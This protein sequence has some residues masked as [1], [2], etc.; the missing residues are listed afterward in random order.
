MTTD[1]FKPYGIGTLELRNRFVRSATWDAT[2]DSSGTVTDNSVALYRELGQGGVG[3]IVTGYAYISPLG[4]TLHGQYGAHTNDMIPGLRRLVQV[5]HQG[6][7]KIALQIV[8][9]GIYSA[10]LSQRSIMSLAVSMMPEINNPHR[11]MTEEEIVAIIS[12]FASAA[13]RAREAGFDAVQLHGAH[14]FLMSQFLSP[15][16]NCRTDRWGSSP[17]NRRRFHIE[18][19]ERIRKVV[20]T[21]FPLMIKFGVQDDKE[22]GLTLSEGLETVH[23][24]VEH[25]IAAIEVSAGFGMPTQ[26]RK[27]GELEQA[28]FRERAATVK[29]TV[30]VPVTA[31][32][33]IRS[34]EM[35]QGIVESGDA[36]LVAMCRPFIRESNL[37][38]RWQSG[39]CEPARCIS[40]NLCFSIARKGEPL[41][42]AQERRIR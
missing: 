9:A 23:Y 1:L 25:G 35:T 42:C 41:D 2:A 5:A 8:H 7:A 33:G 19:I 26:V 15:I 22:G 32:G 20:G 30:M 4:Q 40:C 29:R 6:G 18:I 16:H 31:V 36:D 3:L 34:L 24:M 28:Y 17:E 39:D 12:D 10:Y 13:G 11:E 21:D 38:N 14:G 37:I 27:E